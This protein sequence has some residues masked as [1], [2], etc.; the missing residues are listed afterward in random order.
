MK[1]A[2]LLALLS[3]RGP[4]PVVEAPGEVAGWRFAGAP[5]VS[6]AS[7]V[8][9]TV[10]GALFAYR[11]LS[12]FQD[13]NDGASLSGS[14]S[15]RGP[16]SVDIGTD[17]RRLFRTTLRSNL[18]LHLGDDPHMP[19]W[20]EGAGL[21][22]LPT[23]AGYGSPPEPYRYHD[24]RVF[25]A[26]TLRLGIVG[27]FGMH[28]RG[29]WLD[30]GVPE[31]SALLA[32][33]APPGARGGRVALAEAG[34]FFDSRDRE[35]NTARGL[36]AGVAAFAAPQVNGF[37]DHAFHGYDVTAR[38]YLPLPLRATLALRGLYDRKIAGL[39][40]QRGERGAVPF[41]ERML[42]EGS[43]YNE[44]LGGGSTIRG[45][46]R[47]RV[48]GDEK[49]LGNVQLR[50][51]LFDSHFFDK[52][53]EYGLDLGLDAGWARQPGYP[54][55]DGAGAGAGLRIVWDRA[56]LLRVELAQARGGDRTLYVAFGEQY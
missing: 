39:P 18:N 40:G 47:Y 25:V 27:P 54:A 4:E 51:S 36:L 14:F 17:H 12:G 20:G 45:I 30:V 48:S 11:P 50:L 23:P 1:L 7:D 6:F 10:G 19:Y 46:A 32:R 37:S 53:Q 28:V 3:A 42:Y 55:V 13:E 26:A 24:R 44:G 52:S 22:G 15:T 41:F 16:R 2:L 33:S 9:L 34:L 38:L 8:G 21:G 29:R 31:Q 49:L 56:I 43:N 5:L 35:V